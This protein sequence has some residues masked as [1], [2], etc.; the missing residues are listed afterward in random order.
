MKGGGGFVVVI[1]I[2]KY[3]TESEYCGAASVAYFEMT[4]IMLRLLLSLSKH[5]TVT[6][7]SSAVTFW[8]FFLDETAVFYF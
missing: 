8:I 1:T 3:H 6:H 4:S 5:T 2:S 7:R